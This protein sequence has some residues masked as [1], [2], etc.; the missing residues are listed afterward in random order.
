MLLL[1]FAAI[2]VSA[3]PTLGAHGLC[4]LAQTLRKTPHTLPCNV[5]FRRLGFAKT[6]ARKGAR[7]FAG[8]ACQ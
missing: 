4:K 5:A 7:A 2:V 1:L 3:K 8:M 6:E